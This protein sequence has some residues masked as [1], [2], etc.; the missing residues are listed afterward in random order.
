MH[1]VDAREEILKTEKMIKD[2]KEVTGEACSIRNDRSNIIVDVCSAWVSYHA[3]LLNMEFER[4]RISLEFIKQMQ[5]PHLYI[6]SALVKI[7]RQNG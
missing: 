4:D 7:A 5:G 3:L 2:G 1:R 6:S